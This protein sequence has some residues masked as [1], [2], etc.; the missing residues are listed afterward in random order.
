MMASREK[1]RSGVPHSADQGQPV[2]LPNKRD[3]RGGTTGSASA[4]S[5]VS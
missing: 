5:K 1:A 3:R 4:K 2:I